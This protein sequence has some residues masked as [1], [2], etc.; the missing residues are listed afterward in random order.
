MTAA[1]CTF[2]TIEE[3]A[4]T[5]IFCSVDESLEKV[6]GKYFSDCKVTKESTTTKDGNLERALWDA[7]AKLTGFTSK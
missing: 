2:Q 5:S 4:Q 3:G 1:N 6:T 7:T